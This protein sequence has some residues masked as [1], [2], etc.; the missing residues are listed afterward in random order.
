MLGAIIGDIC[1]SIYE[2]EP[3]QRDDF[4]LLQNRE[5]HNFTDETV[6][7][8]AIAET[9]L[10]DKKEYYSDLSEYVDFFPLKPYGTWFRHWATSTSL[11]PY[12]SYGNGAASRVCALGF[13]AKSELEALE[14]ARYSAKVTHSHPEGIKGAQAVALGI[15]MA[16][17]NASKTEIKE[18]IE[19]EFG[20]NLSRT[21]VGIRK[22]YRFDIT[23]QGSVPEAFIAFFESTSFVTAIE[24]AILLRG[25][26][27]TQASIAGAL[28]EAYYKQIPYIL[29]EHALKLLPEKIKGI[30]ELFY[31]RYSPLAEERNI[32][33]ENRRFRSYRDPLKEKPQAQDIQGQEIIDCILHSRGRRFFSE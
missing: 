21:L 10:F 18:R 31:E 22:N 11:E 26:A 29:I 28:A 8:T 5:Y 24:N 19:K 3:V 15:Y 20:Y 7:L 25:D 32:K 6:L 17:R 27:D 4:A 13:L 16:C 14:E 1:G 33:L 30:L 2:R 12:N 9:Y 23:A